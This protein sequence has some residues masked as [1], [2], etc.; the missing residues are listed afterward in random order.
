LRCT[1]LA[2][3]YQE[4]QDPQKRETQQTPQTQE[5]AVP[6]TDRWLSVAEAAPRIGRS[7]SATL[8]LIRKKA[9]KAIRHTPGGKYQIRES[10]CDRYLAELEAAASAA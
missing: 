1:R 7:P 9:I 3:L 5:G 8:V 2:V 10:E 4:K 6:N